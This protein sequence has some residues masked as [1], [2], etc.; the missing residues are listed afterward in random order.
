M[1]EKK[2]PASR[3]WADGDGDRVRVIAAPEVPPTRS[4]AFLGS[5]VSGVYLTAAQCREVAAHLTELADY[6]E[7]TMPRTVPALPTDPT[8]LAREVLDADKV[9]DST[10]GTLYLDGP[11][12]EHEE[13]ASAI[14]D[15]APALARAVLNA[16]RLARAEEY[17]ASREFAEGAWGGASMRLEFADALRAALNGGNQ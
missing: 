3:V 16:A 10:P 12:H 15:A 5:S 14:L 17:R 11:T 13:A 7:E 2:K 9:R 6:H 1:S 8:A 4:A